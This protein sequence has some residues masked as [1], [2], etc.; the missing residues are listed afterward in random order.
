[1]SLRYPRGAEWRVWDFQVH[2]PYSVLNNGF[3]A[4]FDVYAK[5]FFEK[6][7]EKGGRCWRYGLFRR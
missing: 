1:M 2:T 5:V 6:A 3:G 4:D 7:I